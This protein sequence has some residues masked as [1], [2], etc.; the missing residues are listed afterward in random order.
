MTE[1]S[2]V[3]PCFNPPENW[4]RNI[5]SVFS[6]FCSKAG[7]VPELI[8]VLDG[9]SVVP[10]S[11]PV[12]AL[13]AAIPTLKL[14][15]YNQNTGK[16]FAIR[17]GAAVATGRW[18]MYTDIDF[19]YNI[20]SMLQVYYSLQS[21]S[22]DVAVGIKDEH[23]YSH[24]PFVRR[25]ISRCLRWLIRT[26]LRMPVTDTQCGLKG[27]SASVKPVF[28][29]TTINRY[30]FDLEFIRNC[31]AG[32]RIKVQP[33]P[34][35]LNDNVHFRKMNYSILLPEMMNFIKLLFRKPDG[36]R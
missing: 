13:Q 21:G 2:L 20:E 33:I 28:L 5:I 11:A 29:A 3:L 32:G 36:N 7:T 31:F 6:E 15:H 16:G 4:E 14:V 27:F 19:P 30:L 23:Y 24:L 9:D 17:K 10:G 8:I 25:Q 34:V 26:F 18:I 22:C 35:T 12:L 1:L